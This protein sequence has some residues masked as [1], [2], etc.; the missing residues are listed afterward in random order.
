MTKSNKKNKSQRFFGEL[1]KLP[2]G[3]FQAKKIQK[4]VTI[5]QH[6]KIWQSWDSNKFALD[7][8]NS[9]LVIN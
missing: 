3:K 2:N 7:V 9:G 5:N 4:L 1:V 6:K 8:Q